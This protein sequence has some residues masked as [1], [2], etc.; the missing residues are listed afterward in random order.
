M[1][2][3]CHGVVWVDWAG[4][5]IPA[6]ANWMNVIPQMMLQIQPTMTMNVSS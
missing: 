3:E 1:R 2:R 6:I 5:G 4:W